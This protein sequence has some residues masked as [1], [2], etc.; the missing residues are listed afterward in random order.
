MQPAT[1]VDP[2][3]ETFP[4]QVKGFEAF[5]GLGRLPMVGRRPQGPGMT[6]W[7]IGSARKLSLRV[8]R[9]LSR[10]V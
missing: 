7:Q 8:N 1:S 9:E 10:K 6:T 2:E 5:A 4:H 3:P